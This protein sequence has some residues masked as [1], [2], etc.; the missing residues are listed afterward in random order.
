VITSGVVDF[1]TVSSEGL[2]SFPS[3]ESRAG[4]KGWRLTASSEGQIVVLD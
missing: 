2:E 4:L 3:A 1:Q